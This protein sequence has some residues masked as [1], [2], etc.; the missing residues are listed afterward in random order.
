V[1][2]CLGR[3]EGNSAPHGVAMTRTNP[4]WPQGHRQDQSLF[5]AESFQDRSRAVGPVLGAPT[6]HLIALWWLGAL[7]VFTAG[8][9]TLAFQGRF[10]VIGI[11][12]TMLAFVVLGNPSAGGAYSQLYF[13]P[14]GGPAATLCPTAPGSIGPADRLLQC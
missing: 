2:S 14:F 9:I 10:G 1:G 13:R 8:A 7:V 6:G 3:P 11:G 4:T 5:S 12:L